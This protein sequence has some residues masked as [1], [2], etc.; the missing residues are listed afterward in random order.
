MSKIIEEYIAQNHFGRFLGMEFKIIE[1]GKINY[2]MTAMKNLEA[3]E[4]M[5]HGGAIAGFVDGVLGVTAL[6]AVES[7][8][9]NVATIEF[10]I[11]YLKPIQTGSQLLGEGAV[12]SQGKSIIVTEGKIYSNGALAA[13][14]LG[15]FKTYLKPN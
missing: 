7:E 1:P 4:G 11:N 13:V 9:K 15:T 12:I 3:I 8:G 5:T 14:A 2:T 6:S 10:K